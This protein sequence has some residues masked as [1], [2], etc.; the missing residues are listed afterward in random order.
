LPAQLSDTINGGLGLG[1]DESGTTTTVRRRSFSTFAVM[2]RHGRVFLI[3]DPRVGSSR[4]HQTSP[5][6]GIPI[7][8]G[9]DI[10]RFDDF[11]VQQIEFPF[12]RSNLRIAV[13]NLTG[14]NKLPI[15]LFQPVREGLR[16]IARA[17]PG[18][19]TADENRRQIGR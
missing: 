4:T 10:R 11:V 12:Y 17:F 18:R 9:G 7:D 3:S 1:E 15:A 8:F 16:Q 14:G 5:L 19:Y 13:S 6:F 2:I